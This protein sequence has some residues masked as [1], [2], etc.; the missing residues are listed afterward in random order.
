MEKKTVDFMD[1]LNNEESYSLLERIEE[2]VGE[3]ES[4]LVRIRKLMIKE[5]KEKFGYTYAE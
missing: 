5:M 3:T 2:L 1:I 4:E